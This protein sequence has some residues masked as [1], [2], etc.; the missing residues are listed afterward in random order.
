MSTVR[1]HLNR[2]DQRPSSAA[3]DAQPADAR[4]ASVQRS[5]PTRVRHVVPAAPR[6]RDRRLIPPRRPVDFRG[7]P[8]RPSPR[9][10]GLAAP[11]TGMLE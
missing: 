9:P 1:P 10:L 8:R 3:P 6:P 11:P 7:A 2:P 5:R 4:H